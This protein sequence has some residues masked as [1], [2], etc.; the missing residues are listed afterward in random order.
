MSN[1]RQSIPFDT[2][3]IWSINL[4]LI[5]AVLVFPQFLLHENVQDW[6]APRYFSQ[7]HS[8]PLYARSPT[9]AVHGAAVLLSQRVCLWSKGGRSGAWECGASAAAPSA[10]TEAF[11]A[12]IDQLQ[13]FIAIVTG[14][15]L[16]GP[17]QAHY[18]MACTKRKSRQ[19]PRRRSRLVAATNATAAAAA[20]RAAAAAGCTTCPRRRGRPAS[21]V[22]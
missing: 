19:K 16:V 7:W 10:D 3:H 6:A 4:H 5:W 9:W 14:L 13:R 8:I 20:T 22:F 1:E 18:Q 2:L 12:A 15:F 11:S 21:S 17:Q